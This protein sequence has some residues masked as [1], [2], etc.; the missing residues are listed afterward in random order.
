M[1]LTWGIILL[2]FGT[3]APGNLRADGGT[4]RVA[5]VPMGTYRVNVFTAPTPIPPDSVDVSVL[6][7]FERGRGVATGLEIMVTGRRVDGTGSPVRH[8]ATR[9]EAQD[10]RYYAAK[11][12]LGSVGEWEITVEV[13]GPEGSGEVAFLVTVQ[14][15]GLLQNPFMILGLALLPLLLVGL[16]LRTSAREQSSAQ[17]VN[18]RSNHPEG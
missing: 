6:A 10:P 18:P 8:A 16:W 4:L 1:A 15:P 2:L 3:L 7:T 9:E 12:A 14:E 13:T 17:S 11:F 5:N